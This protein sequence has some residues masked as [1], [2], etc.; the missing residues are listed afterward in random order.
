MATNTSTPYDALASETLPTE[1]V[2]KRILAFS[3]IDSTNTYALEH[4]EDGLVIVADQQSAGRGRLGR[5]WH[6]APGVGIWFTVCFDG[7]VQGL[8]FA[9]ALAVQEVLLPRCAVKIKWPN[10]ILFEGRKICGIL[11]EHRNGRTALGIGLNV[12]QRSEDFPEELRDKAGSL[13]SI[14]GESWDRSGL[15]RDILIAL[16]QWVKL[17]REGRLEK[18]VDAWSRECNLVGQR[19]KSGEIE[20]IVQE[21]DSIGAL[22]V[23]TASGI[24]RVLSG[25]IEL[26]SGDE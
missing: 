20:G 19:I 8:T 23:R 6:S 1:F 12:H 11:V 3:T 17:I 18:V 5:S 16:D 13:E 14:T 7:L 24:E 2:G 21:I 26:V 4:G 9:S 15:L 10:D 22:I 25:E